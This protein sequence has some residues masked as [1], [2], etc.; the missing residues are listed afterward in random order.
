MRRLP[1][2]IKDNE[3]MNRKFQRAVVLAT[4]IGFIAILLVA[5][6]SSR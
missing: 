4:V 2:A 6:V 3:C 1:C 5:T